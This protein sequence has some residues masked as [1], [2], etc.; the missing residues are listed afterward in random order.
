MKKEKFF[1]NLYIFLSEE[2]CKIIST[3]VTLT[4]SLNAQ[5]CP[6]ET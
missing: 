1:N 6:A 5:T 2:I 3:I 4:F